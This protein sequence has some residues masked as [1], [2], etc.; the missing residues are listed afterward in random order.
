MKR[1]PKLRNGKVDMTWTADLTNL[2]I[3][4]DLAKEL[5]DLN[6]AWPINTKYMVI[7]L[8]PNIEDIG[9]YAVIDSDYNVHWIGGDLIEGLTWVEN[10]NKIFNPE[11]AYLE[12]YDITAID[13]IFGGA[14]KED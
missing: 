13:K 7:D 11:C 4:I 3:D 10:F 9:S 8:T 2:A 14:Y 5:R 6:R 1:E 12:S